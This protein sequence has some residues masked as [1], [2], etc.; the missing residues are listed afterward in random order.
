MGSLLALKLPSLGV[1]RRG[2]SG[3]PLPLFPPVWLPGLATVRMKGES[4]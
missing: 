4:S 3:F 2:A 1:D